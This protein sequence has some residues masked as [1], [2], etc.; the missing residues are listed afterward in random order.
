[1]KTRYWILIFAVLL[2]VMIL[3]A[4]VIPRV[5]TG[6]VANIY[7]DGKCIMSID[8]S[9]VE[10]PYSFTLEE[11]GHVNTVE[12]ER[13]R[14]RVVSANCPD[15]VCVNTGWIE[16]GLRP[17]VCLPAKLVIK[18]E[19]KAAAEDFDAVTGYYGL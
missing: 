12:V 8:L 1:M 10:E 17:I 14:I 2:A 6:S 16:G 13:G 7:R 9:A 19:S 4:V 11:D 5:N 3:A 18:V 15:G